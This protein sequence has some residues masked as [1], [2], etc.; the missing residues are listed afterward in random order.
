VASVKKSLAAKVEVR[1]NS[2]CKLGPRTSAD[3]RGFGNG[4]HLI[5][6]GPA[7]I[8][9][10]N[11]PGARGE[12]MNF[13]AVHVAYSEISAREDARFRWKEARYRL[14]PAASVKPVD[15]E[16]ARTI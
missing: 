12:K 14:L 2:F 13:A 5:L 9:G 3:T 4:I 10:P 8:R 15:V 6:R 11:N 1:A 16:R 7:S